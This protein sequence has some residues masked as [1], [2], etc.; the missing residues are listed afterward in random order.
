MLLGKKHENYAYKITRCLVTFQVKASH[1]TI[2][3]RHWGESIPVWAANWLWLQSAAAPF[4]CTR[5]R[6]GTSGFGKESTEPGH[7]PDFG[8]YQ[9]TDNRQKGH[10]MELGANEPRLRA[11]C[12]AQM[13]RR[14]CPWHD[15]A[16]AGF[17]YGNSQC[18][19]HKH[20]HKTPL[21]GAVT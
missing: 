1:W 13:C 21:R 20:A 11:W 12:G 14:I 10:K 6:K 15:T 3:E 4:Q 7:L 16:A 18:G 5:G 8:R 19:I 2:F 17:A 9:K